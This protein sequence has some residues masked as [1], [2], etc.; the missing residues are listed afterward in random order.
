MHIFRIGSSLPALTVVVP[1]LFNFLTADLIMAAPYHT[2]KRDSMG[3]EIFLKS[4]INVTVSTCLFSSLGKIKVKLTFN[5]ILLIE[6]ITCGV[7]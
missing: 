2:I 5:P 1:Y 7:Y 6:L 3:S 4:R